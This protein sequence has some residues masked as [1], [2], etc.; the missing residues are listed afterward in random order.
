MQDE[1][2]SQTDPLYII[3]AYHSDGGT[4]LAVKRPDFDMT[5][6]Q[7][8]LDNDVILNTDDNSNVKFSMKVN[9]NWTLNKRVLIMN[10]SFFNCNVTPLRKRYLIQMNVKGRNHNEH[11]YQHSAPTTFPSKDEI[12][13]PDSIT[14][15]I[16]IY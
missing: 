6:W 4:V 12:T 16:I 1:Y 14:V 10:C 8:C 11:T 3:N 15:L 5:R 2:L 7:N 9:L 13:A